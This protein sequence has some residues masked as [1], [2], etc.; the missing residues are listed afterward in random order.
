MVSGDVSRR[1]VLS[2]LGAGGVV[3]LAGCSGGGDDSGNGGDSENGEGSEGDGT[4]DSTDQQEAR[5]V[6]GV[7]QDL[8]GPNG[9]VFGH[10][11]ITGF[12]SG[13]A[14]KADSS[15]PG[16]PGDLQD[17]DGAERSYDVS[18]TTVALRIRDTESNPQNAQTLAT[19]LLDGGADVLFGF[20]TS[21]SLTRYLNLSIDGTEAPVFAGQATASDITADD[22]LCHPQLFR[23]TET[24]EMNARAG[25][26][27]LGDR[28]G[29]QRAAILATETRFGRAQLANYRQVFQEEGIELV[30]DG[31]FEPGRANWETTLRELDEQGVD[32]VVYA[33]PAGSGQFFALDFATTEHGMQAI[34]NMPSRQ[35]LEP[36]GRQLSALA[37][38]RA[39]R[40]LLTPRFIDSIG[41]G[42]LTDGYHFNQYDNEINDWLVE[43]Q[44]ATYGVFP[45]LFTSSAFV[46]A[47]AIIQAVEQAGETSADAV[48]EEV[49]GMTVTDTPKGENA[50]EFQ[51]HNNQA[52]S[53]MTVAPIRPIDDEN[54]P[55]SIAPGEP[56]TRLSRDETTAGPD[57]ESVSCDLS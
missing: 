14:Y 43:Q 13:L 6:V 56:V 20:S 36:L 50:Y 24:T 25:G 15:P 1:Q 40:G 9:P 27:Y 26:A 2:S 28:P 42:P 16:V 4:G 44:A 3:A 48:L 51:P 41:V 17:L 7:L 52:R 19:E 29:L 34:G 18:G 32:V 37:A 23:A 30:R 31:L 35:T 33:M 57:S 45:D 10:Q 39:R 8:S 22:G 55:A 47:S 46:S 53:P 54:W 49:P 12:L 38:D 11:G 21:E 5:I